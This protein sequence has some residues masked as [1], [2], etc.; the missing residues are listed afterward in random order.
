MKK[1]LDKVNT[2]YAA[3]LSSDDYPGKAGMLMAQA[4]FLRKALS[5]VV[6]TMQARPEYKSEPWM[7]GLVHTCSFE[8]ELTEYL[9]QPNRLQDDRT[10]SGGMNKTATGYVEEPTCTDKA[11]FK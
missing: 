3:V 1:E 7:A 8:L 4:R 11:D 2:K 5:V 9:A 10:V 6:E